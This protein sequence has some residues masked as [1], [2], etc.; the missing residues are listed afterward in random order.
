[1][2][3]IFRSVAV[4]CWLASADVPSA[5]QRLGSAERSL[6][7]AMTSQFEQSNRHVE[8]MV[9]TA[10]RISRRGHGIL[11]TDE[12]VPTA[13]KRLETIGMAN[14]E[15]NRRSFRE[16]LYTTEGLGKYISGV[17]L[18]DEAMHQRTA[19]GALFTERLRDEGI[20]VGIKVDTGLQPLAGTNG[21][22]LTQGL[23]GLGERCRA[24][25]RLG[26][27]FAKWRA[28]LKIGEVPRSDRAHA[29]ARRAHTR[30]M[31]A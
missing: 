1:M 20:A 28:V 30:P 13:G 14:N 24:Y 7:I 5:R 8:E 11:A 29:C 10:Q 23:D 22:T 4:A 19:D 18:F 12:S 9:A 16:M 21:E 26:A 15:A 3:G 17:I 27:R 6:P 2:L 31:H 25:Y